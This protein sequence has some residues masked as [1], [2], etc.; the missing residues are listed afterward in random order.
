MRVINAVVC[1]LDGTLVRT[2]NVVLSE[3]VDMLRAVR[4]QG[5]RTLLITGRP[6]RCLWDMPAELWPLFTTIFTS[7]GASC[8]T[9]GQLNIVAPLDADRGLRFAVKLRAI[10]P[11]VVFAT[12]FENTFGHEPKYAWWPATDTDPAA[13][14]GGIDDLF[15]YRSLVTKLLCRSAVLNA[16]E[17][18]RVAEAVDPGVTVTYSCRPSEGGPVEVMAPSASKGHAVHRDLDFA[19]IDPRTAVAFGDRYNDFPML[20][21]VGRG[22]A[23][24][25]SI[26]PQ[27]SA[28]ESALSVGQWLAANQK[29]WSKT[30]TNGVNH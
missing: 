9:A 15:G 14:C 20:D 16:R 1:D 4:A 5:I 26:D 25:V 30:D 10:D 22:I 23:I 18:A 28:F 19:G 2:G 24:G 7:N 3:D 17:L 6:S 29:S 13:L 11:T 12:E 8:F 21:T 27:L